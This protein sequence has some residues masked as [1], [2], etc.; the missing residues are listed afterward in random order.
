MISLQVVKLPDYVV[1]QFNVNVA[2][3]DSRLKLIVLLLS[4]VD[5]KSVNFSKFEFVPTCINFNWYLKF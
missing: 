4:N 2:T 5:T 3:F 1:Q